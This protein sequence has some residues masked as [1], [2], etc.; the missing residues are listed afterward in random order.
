VP[1][2]R[3]RRKATQAFH[4]L[5]VL[6]LIWQSSP[7]WTAARAVVLVVQGILPLLSL[8]LLKLIIDQVVASLQ[9]PD[10]V[11]AFQQALF[12]L[13]L[14][15]FVM[16][17]ISALTSLSELV[18]A[19]QTQR[20]TDYMQE[21][22]FQKSAAVDLEYY[23]NSRYY[24]TLQR[25]Q[26]E[27]PFRPNQI[28]N[29]IAQVVQNGVSLAGIFVF[30]VSL[31]WF[32]AGVLIVAALPALW[33]RLRFANIR[34]QWQRQRTPLERRSIYFSMLLAQDQFAK[35]VRLFNLG[36]LFRERIRATR[37]QIY[38]E[39]LRL[40]VRRA[41]ANLSAE[42][43]AQMLTIGVFVYIAHQTIQG[44]LKIGDL[45]IYQQVL[46]RG[47]AA[48]QGV[49]NGFSGLY[50]D[51]LFL[52]NL[53]EFLNLEPKIVDP[54]QP[55]P[56]PNPI[57][58]GISL[59]Q[60]SFQYGDTTRQAL[61]DI[62]LKI[63]PGE[64]IA[65]VGENG[66]GKTTLVKLLCRLYEPTAGRI[67]IDGIDLRNF[68]L[69]DLRQ[70]IS[71]IFQDYAK[72]HFSA[73]ENIW[74]GNIQTPTDYAIIHAAQRAGAHDVIQQLPQGYDTVLGKLFE[75]GEELSIGQWQKVALARAFLRNAQLIILDEPT[76]AM[77]PRAEYEVFQRFRELT[78]DQMAVI[79]SHRLSTVKMADRIY[80]MS[81]GRIAEEGTHEELVQM[82][83][84][85]ADLYETQ[86]HNYR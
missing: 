39:N 62:S 31:Y 66:S 65:L 38:R 59:E 85:Y 45:V 78:Q 57:Q 18:S 49:L 50:E 24:D 5:P 43:F 69:T 79:I 44:N 12:L 61:Q 71:V 53:Y 41:I 73:R 14:L 51:N 9:A 13:L 27:A 32:L 36:A 35:E 2:G 34:Y 22:L 58:Q 1:L 25:A 26:Q 23:E 52:N 19:A 47:E 7:R 83:G 82:K 77:D 76:S 17:L 56:V 30:L 20:V 80:L 29:R 84:A 67:L 33:V 10:R 46:Q 37:Q 70:Q 63:R 15:G 81:H 64:T 4:L 28:L 6:Q 42:S 60:V 55:T 3:L 40:L 11:L 86:A 16:L 54:L 75:N 21:L 74:L 72:Y 8:F 68:T 48:L